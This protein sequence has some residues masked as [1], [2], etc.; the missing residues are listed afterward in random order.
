MKS[1]SCEKSSPPAPAAARLS[2]II[3]G[4]ETGNAAHFGLAKLQM[5]VLTLIVI[6]AYGLSIVKASGA[7]REHSCN[8]RHKPCRVHHAKGNH[9]K[10]DRQVLMPTASK[11]RAAQC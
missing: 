2:D 10:R 11:E 9:T 4:V 1:V 8:H 7:R 5:L 3:T 6:L